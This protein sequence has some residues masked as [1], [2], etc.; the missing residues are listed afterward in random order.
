MTTATTMTQNAAYT[1]LK[2]FVKDI[3]TSRLKS[4]WYSFFGI[5]Q[6]RQVELKGYN[7]WLQVY[8]VDGVNYGNCMDRKVGEF[9][10]DL[11][12]PFSR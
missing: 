3:N 7:T 6:G 10:S 9:K 8:R 1:D 11:E 4:G 2:Q 12:R 5:V